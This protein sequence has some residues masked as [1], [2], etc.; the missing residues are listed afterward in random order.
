MTRYN[1]L[2]R[3]RRS[4][5]TAAPSQPLKIAVAVSGGPDSVCLL[6]LLAG[7]A[8]KLNLALAVAHL[9]HNLRGKESDGDERFVA[10]L[11][12][13]LALPFHRASADLSSPPGN[14]EQQ[15]RRARRAFFA[16]LRSRG[17]A[18]RIALGH[19]LDD[20][21]ETVLFRL[22]RG[23]GPSGLAGI[24]PVT[25]EGMIRPLIQST[26]ADVL[27]YLRSHEIAWREDSSNRDPRFARN[28]IRHS[29]MP[30]L[31]AHWN[32]QIRANLSHLA[33]VAYEEERFWGARIAKLAAERLV[34]RAGGVEFLVDGLAGLPRAASRR[35]VR[36]A[37]Q[38][39]KGD[40]RRVEYG[41]IE[42]V[43]EL[44][45]RREGEGAVQIPGLVASRSFE[46]LRI[47]PPALDF[48][49]LGVALTVP[50]EFP[51]PDG[52][53]CIHLEIQDKNEVGRPYGT[54]KT[55][56]L[57]LSRIPQPLELRGWKPGDHYQPLGQSRERKLT[58]LF[59]R[60]RVPSWR[61]PFWPIVTGG[62]KILWARDFGVA[63]EIAAGTGPVLRIWEV[64]VRDC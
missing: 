15:A 38:L 51:W 23:T 50:G 1:M 62:D 3:E 47:A 24:L 39:A 48:P 4:N 31:E 12:H 30:E 63:Q 22:I 21:A 45:D 61:R 44:C 46:W 25:S 14:L 7:L 40:L 10:E 9:N 60:A 55:A 6:H 11:A 32:P 26:R 54:L 42:R 17:L 43:L 49:P 33:D 58:E 59:Q 13:R 18:D 37:I 16:N 34:R 41:H 29:L 52:G 36:H 28:R 57:D 5:A 27:D 53:S 8:A 20:Q 56:E 19:T 35:L 64:E 2:G